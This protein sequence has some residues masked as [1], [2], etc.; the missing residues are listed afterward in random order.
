VLLTPGEGGDYKRE[1]KI[2][3]AFFVCLFNRT[4]KVLK[5][6]ADREHGK[7]KMKYSLSCR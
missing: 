6:L 1:E 5:T 4:Q 2:P 3:E 7:K